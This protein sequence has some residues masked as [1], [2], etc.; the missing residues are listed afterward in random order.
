GTQISKIKNLK[1]E[2]IIDLKGWWKLLNARAAVERSRIKRLEI[3]NHVEHRYRIFEQDSVDRNLITEEEA[4]LERTILHFQQQFQKRRTHL[5]SM[6][7][8]W[9]RIY[10]P[11]EKIKERPSGIGYRLIKQ[12]SISSQ[13]IFRQ[14]ANKCLIE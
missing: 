7:N 9:S 12:A 6:S 8:E 11:L 13:E 2:V 3:E 10:K 1:E 14:L 4:V 5:S